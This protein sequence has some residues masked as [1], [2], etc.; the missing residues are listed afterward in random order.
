MNEKT[1][2]DEAL[3]MFVKKEIGGFEYR[4]LLCGHPR[5]SYRVRH[6]GNGSFAIHE[7]NSLGQQG[8]GNYQ[9]LNDEGIAQLRK[10][11]VEKKLKREKWLL[12]FLANPSEPLPGIFVELD[13]LEQNFEKLEV[14][15]VTPEEMQADFKR[16]TD[17]RAEL[18]RPTY[19]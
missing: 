1:T 16:L 11:H 17:A 5:P 7:V 3:E 13:A 10:Y 14:Q 2:F 9:Q 8:S 4:Q 15:E 19:G 6:F 12:D 18:R